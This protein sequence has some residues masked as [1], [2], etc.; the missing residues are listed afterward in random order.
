MLALEALKLLQLMITLFLTTAASIATVGQD[1]MT[2]EQK[3]KH[4]Y[5]D[6]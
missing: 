5:L 4:I 3:E 6:R 1:A 2:Q